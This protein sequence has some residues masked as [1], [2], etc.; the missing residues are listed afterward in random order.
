MQSTRV[1]PLADSLYQRESGNTKPINNLL[2]TH[3]AGLRQT[4]PLPI[5]LMFATTTPGAKS[6]STLE[7]SV[8]TTDQ[9]SMCLQAF[10]FGEKKCKVPDLIFLLP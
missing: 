6:A 8:S 5:L 3:L 9:S 10:S 7:Q 1:S 2:S 4:H